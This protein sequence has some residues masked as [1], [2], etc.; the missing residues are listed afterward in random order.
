MTFSYTGAASGPV[1]AV[2]FAIGDTI[3][4]TSR[5]S[6][7][8]IAYLLEQTNG[9]VRQA[10]RLACENI[11]ASLSGL[12]DQSVG[13]V[14]KSFSQIRDG[15]KATLVMLKSRTSYLGGKPFVGGVSRMANAIDARNPDRVRPQFTTQMLRDR[16]RDAP[17][18]RRHGLGVT[19]DERLDADGTTD[20]DGDGR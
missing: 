13:S 12:C 11:I 18:Y 6:D 16:R 2:R 9:N 5:I 7:E 19:F 17:E 20:G 4:A 15:Y 3:E 1:G 10:A 14:S 8:D